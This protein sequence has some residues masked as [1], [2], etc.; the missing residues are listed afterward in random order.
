MNASARLPKS[1]APQVI[2]YDIDTAGGQSGSPVWHY[3]AGRRTAVGIHT[4]GSSLGNSATRLTPAL[5]AILN[6]WRAMGP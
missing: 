6:R 2:T 5:V 3:E 1:V 4:N